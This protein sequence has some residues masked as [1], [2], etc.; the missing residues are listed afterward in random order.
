MR[1]L[2]TSQPK[3]DLFPSSYLVYPV[4]TLHCIKVSMD[5]I[6][7]FSLGASVCSTLHCPENDGS[8]VVFAYLTIVVD[9]IFPDND[10]PSTPFVSLILLR[11]P[12][13]YERS[14]CPLLSSPCFSSLLDGSE[15]I[16][17][18]IRFVSCCV[19]INLSTTSQ[20]TAS[21]EP[22][23]RHVRKQPP[24][25]VHRI[26]RRLRCVQLVQ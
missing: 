14:G 11:N 3:S 1:R 26:P 8:P 5:N 13:F 23:S 10:V 20:L 12:E 4:F 15:H 6:A 16:M 9:S 18:G 2:R 19:L 17:H 24:H 25:C 7:I 21:A 22:N